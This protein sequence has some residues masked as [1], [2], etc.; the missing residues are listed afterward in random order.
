MVGGEFSFDDVKDMLVFIHTAIKNVVDSM[1]IKL[2]SDSGATKGYRILGDLK[3]L[4]PLCQEYLKLLVVVKQNFE[5][6][7][8]TSG[9]EFEDIICDLR[10]LSDEEVEEVRDFIRKKMMEK[11][12][13]K[14]E[15]GKER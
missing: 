12:K 3:L 10:E 6:F 11:V 1:R 9:S 13:K 4:L 14:W 7:F 2:D 5:E 8:K 15:E